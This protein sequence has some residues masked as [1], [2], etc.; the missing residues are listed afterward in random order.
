MRLGTGTAAKTRTP[1]RE[2]R[3]ARPGGAT[4]H[5]RAVCHVCVPNLSRE[6]EAV[7]CP[8]GRQPLALPN[9][10][11]RPRISIDLLGLVSAYALVG[12]VKDIIV[13]CLSNLRG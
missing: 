12:S 7:M 10:V 13:A 4:R 2:C 6:S 1:R 11:C 8:L 3:V 9:A 5:Y